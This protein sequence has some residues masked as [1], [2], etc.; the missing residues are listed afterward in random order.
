MAK[1]KDD[2]LT[3]EVFEPVK[4]PEIKPLPDIPH[5]LIPKGKTK[6]D[7]INAH[8]GQVLH[9]YRTAAGLVWVDGTNRKKFLEYVKECIKIT[10]GVAVFKEV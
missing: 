5:G 1:K 10:D 8:K 7:I 4:E 6:R 3:L 9:F 2:D